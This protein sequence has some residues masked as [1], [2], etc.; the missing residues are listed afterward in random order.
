MPV[1]NIKALK[2]SLRQHYREYRENLDS[3]QKKALDYEMHQRLWKLPA[4]RKSQLIFTYVSKPIEVDTH[5]LIATALSQHKSVAVPR[6]IENNEMEFYEIHSFD[7]LTPGNFGV[8]E[9]LPEKCRK[10]TDLSQGLCIVPGFSFD[11]NGF[12]L[13][14][15]KGYYDRFL[16][17]FAGDTVGLC[18]SA[19]VQW[20]LPHGYYDRPVDVL[21]TEKYIRRIS[22]EKFAGGK[23]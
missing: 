16:M 1:K 23:A 7:D 5:I 8:L 12:R 22:H 15:G 19:C 10:V 20:N 2:I 18:Y 4:Y 3:S 21:V 11:S 17:K 14:Y 6:C 13:G 9:P